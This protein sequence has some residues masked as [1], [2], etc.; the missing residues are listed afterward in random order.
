MPNDLE[1]RL[2][3]HFIPGSFNVMP[4][5]KFSR[6][7]FLID[8]GLYFPAMIRSGDILHILGELCFAKKIQ[9]IDACGYVYCTRPSQTTLQPVEKEFRQFLESMPAAIE[10][11]HA[12]FSSP[13]MVSKLSRQFQN[14][15]EVNVICL[16]FNTHIVRAYSG[17]LTVEQIDEILREVLYQPQMMNPEM[18][19]AF[20]NTIALL[21]SGK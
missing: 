19:R 14:V 15:F 1:T 6:R 3:D 9:I 13:K 4:W 5:L 16:L 18:T 2:N 21:L 12:L 7:D 20:I 10:F 17:E 8:S 11:I